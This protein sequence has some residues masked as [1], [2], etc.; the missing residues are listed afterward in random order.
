MT[1]ICPECKSENNDVVAGG[2]FGAIRKCNDCWYEGI[3]PEI[4][5]ENKSEDMNKMLNDMKEAA[6]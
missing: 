3:F 1:I 2:I 5:S 4:S 6:R